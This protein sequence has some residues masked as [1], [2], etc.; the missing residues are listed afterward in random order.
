MRNSL[1]C[2]GLAIFGVAVRALPASATLYGTMSNFDVYNETETE[3]H[4]AEIELEGIHREDLSRDFPSHFNNKTISEYTNGAVFGTRITYTDY[5]FNALGYLA[6]TVGQSTN[7]HAC[8]NTAGCEHFGFSTLGVQPTAANY[9]WLDVNGNRINNAAMQVPTP[10]WTYIPPAVP[11]GAPVLRAEVEPVEVHP[12]QP[13]SVWMKVFKTEF[14]RPVELAELMSA[15]GIVPEDAAE[16]ETEWEL[17]EGGKMDQA[18]DDVPE[19]KKSVIRRYE[20]YQYTGLY[21]PEEHE[22]LSNWNGDG[23][24]PASELGQFISAN[25]VAANLE[26]P[27]RTQGDFNGDG[28]VDAADYT[29]WRNKLGSNDD[30]HGDG[31]DDG[32][33]DIDDYEVW[34]DGFG[35]VLDDGG[36]GGPGPGGAGAAV[37]EP[38]AAGLVL[39]GSAILLVRRVSRISAN[40]GR[41]V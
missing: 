8:V 12:Q 3:A 5:N 39:I 36:N 41:L 34:R 35:N 27:A 30:Y 18:E 1:V 22:A 28:V 14:D 11:G 13:D 25:M 2:V 32:D 6:P 15:N 33:V 26:A 17:L 23:D 10:T 40:R 16:T 20:F 38:A 7:G 4:G 21:D 19:G 9:Y 24:P 29:V 31:N 37:P